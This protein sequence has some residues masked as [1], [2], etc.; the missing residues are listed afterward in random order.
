[1][2]YNRGS[3]SVSGSKMFLGTVPTHTTTLDL[4]TLT[5]VKIK[6]WAATNGFKAPSGLKKAELVQ[7]LNGKIAE[8]AT[9]IVKEGKSA[10]AAIDVLQPR[11]AD[12]NMDWLTHLHIHGWAVAPVPDW[13]PEFTQTF[14][15][16]FESC[17][18]N[19]SSTDRSTWKSA[20]MPTMLHG[21]LKHYF[22]HTELQW[23][24]RELCVPIFARIWGCQPEDLLCSFDGGCFLPC[25]PKEA[26]KNTSFKQWIHCDEPRAYRN[27][28]SVQGIVNFENN[29]PEDGGLVLIEGSNAIFS[30]Y[31]DKHP[32]EGIVWGPSDM[33]DPLL[34]TRQLIKICAPA[35]HIILFDTRTFHC[36]VH[37]WG[38]ILKEDGTPRF[39]MCTY[40]S[41][42]PRLGATQKELDKRIKLYEKGRMS[43]H[44]C[45]G[46]WFKETPEHPHLYGGINI[47]PEVVE[48]APLNPLRSRLIGYP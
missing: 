24:I 5:V 19:F 29:G 4:N 11:M 9:G 15:R 45:Y 17:S 43:S 12:P 23:T 16:W 44:W 27:F 47:R 20:N 34:A 28:S 32:S 31:M 36:N 39:R 48:I 1:L 38:S 35:G 8:K 22:G 6:E 7:Y 37:P 10:V 30:E 26:L 42:Q 40:V 14:L 41:M 3:K 13:N 2:I 25:I 33:T 21:I 46:L 18:L